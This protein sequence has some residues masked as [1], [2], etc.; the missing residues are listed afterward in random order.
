MGIKMFEIAPPVVDTE[1]GHQ[2]R[3]DKNES[4]G[5][6]PVGEFIEGAMDAIKNDRFEAAIELANEMRSKPKAMFKQMNG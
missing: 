1:L 5:G 2:R 4:H 3:E 6:I